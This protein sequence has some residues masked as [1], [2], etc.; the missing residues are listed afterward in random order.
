MKTSKRILNILS[1][2]LLLA[3]AGVVI[4]V[5]VLRLT[6]AKPKLFGYYIFNVVSDSMTPMIN[7]DDVILV[8]ECSG[9]D[10]KKGDIITYRGQSGDFAGK[11]V[12][13]KV[14]EEP[15]TDTCGTIRIQTQGIKEGAI[16]DPVITG[17]Q[18]LGKYV[19][20]MKILS[21][22]FF[23]FRKWYGLVI[24]LLIIFALLGKEVYNLAKL[25][26]KADQVEELTQE[27]L[28]EIIASGN[29]EAL[30]DEQAEQILQAAQAKKE[31]EQSKANK[32]KED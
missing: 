23:I 21:I 7:I 28:K 32:E 22:V 20:T 11:D 2:V 24:F 27:Q 29:A 1:T 3:A 26:R 30:T 9:A 13:H 12:T 6:G 14:I 31:A 15:V 10:V 5:F 18:V 4:F 16:K 25:S 17:E 8:K 19:R